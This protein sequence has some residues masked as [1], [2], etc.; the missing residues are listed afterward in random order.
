MVADKFTGRRC[1]DKLSSS[2][3]L[4]PP[5]PAFFKV[6]PPQAASSL[7]HAFKFGTLRLTSS[8]QAARITYL[9]NTLIKRIGNIFEEALANDPAST[10]TTSQNGA[11][12]HTTTAMQQFQLDVE[13][14]ALVRAAEEIMVLTRSMKDV[15][16]FGGLDTLTTNHNGEHADG[17]Q[18]EDIRTVAGYIQ[19]RLGS[20]EPEVIPQPA[21]VQENGS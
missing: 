8:M 21:E 17:A 6:R 20:E 12:S 5:P 2:W 9:S 11:P 19:K 16:L 7:C 13:S 3:T 10:E 14:T 4:P 15:W 1:V 18:P